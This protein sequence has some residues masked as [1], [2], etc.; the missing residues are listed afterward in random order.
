MIVSIIRAVVR[1]RAV[2]WLLVAALV[3]ASAYAIGTASLDAI[4]DISDPQIVVYAKWPRSA[5]LLETEVTAPLVS[6]LVGSPDIRG[7]R[8]ASH[9]GYA[10]IYVIL[11]D[12]ARR[13]R[14]QQLV[15][16]RL[17]AIRPQLPP[18]A[19]VTLGP[20]ASS[21]GWIYQYALV[22]GQGTHDLRELRLLN[23]SQIKPALQTVPGIA[24]VA[25]VGGLEKQYQIKVYPPLLAKAGIPLKQLI[26]AVQSVFQ[27][28]G[29]RMIEVTN[30]DYQ[31]RGIINSQDLDKLEL[32]VVG[33]TKEGAP[34]RLK[35]I[36]YVQVGYDQRRSTV[37]L[38]GT[39]EVVG[40]I[41]IMDQDGN[42]LAITR[43][44]EQKLQQLRAALPQGI[45]IVTTYDRSA[46]IWSTLRQFVETL[47]V[48]LGVLIVVTLLFLRNLRTAVGP[49]TILLLS[50]LFPVLPLVGF[51]QTVNLFSLAG[52]VIAIGEIADATIVIVEN[53]TAEL[54]AHGPA[55]RAE[56]Q[57]IV[58][59]SIASVAKPLLFSLLIILASFLPVF[60]LEEREARLF[61]PL[62]YSK[63]FAMAF[64]TL[65]TM[66]LLPLIVL[67]IF[68]HEGHAPRRFQETVAARAYR[69][70]LAAVIRYRYAFTGAGM[71]FLIPAAVLLTQFPRDFLPEVDEGAILYM[72]T[73]LPGLP[74]RE[75]GWILQQMDKKL[76]ALP[77]VERVFGK[78][79]RADTSTDPAPLT[80]IE[81]T[82][83]LQPRSKWRQDMTR[84]KLIAE[85]DKAVQT[86]GYVNAWVQPIRARVM[87]QST[88]I[89]TPV[90]LKVKGSDL[91]IIEDISQQVEGLLRA[92]PG[93]KSVIAER[94]S[95]GYYVDVRN[96]LE[97]M[98][99]RNVTVDEAMSTVRHAIGGDN[100]VSVRQADNT[101][102][103]LGVQYSPEYIDTLDKIKS[104]PVVTADGRSVPLGE[105]ADVSVRKMPEMIRNDNGSLAGYIYVDLQ[106][107]TGPDY[108]AGA[109]LML[110]QSL[111]L[112]TGYSIEWTGLYEYAAAARARLRV[113]VPLTLVIIFGLLVVA[114]KSV[115]ESVLIL[116]S[117]PFAM[118]GGVF[119]QWTLGY[120]MTTAVIVGY[121]SLFAVAVQTGIIMVI[122]IRA[123]LDSRK[124]GQSYVDAVLDGSAMRLRP[125][126]MTVAA[127]MLALL[128]VM[129][130][131]GTGME[132]LQPIAAP[133][134]GG[135]VSSTL[136]VLFMT[137]CLF[138]I[139]DDVRCWWER[140]SRA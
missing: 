118:V 73:T 31:L 95:E 6:A 113:I 112:P 37:D 97:R 12:T 35:D 4:P 38:D 3:V 25:S 138:V 63:T 77:E 2:V 79:G 53:C 111:T 82:V 116:L 52:L 85:M 70:A 93:T 91:S 122:F 100:I 107:V 135:M 139:G 130:T 13:D 127:T 105:V 7:I 44:L 33:R 30:R 119:L 45:E 56:R 18:D 83:L 80:M 120:P 64:S 121:I 96:D 98:A 46:W 29:G 78:I 17:N 41:A 55:T 75:A 51:R 36:G 59:R 8:G 74:N 109:Q 108:V 62:A 21:M 125:K 48:E 94:I 61:D 101:I 90:G 15:V 117:V 106:N 133:S 76:K 22:D 49:I 132:I 104:T 43:S 50:T 14:V 71:L 99:E 68:K 27:E 87:M 28:A 19:I 102:V 88:G 23:E 24:E 60:F 84:E 123:A 134:I 11:N 72:P 89:Q 57:E 69:T 40:G 129:F 136:H 16:D 131:S 47:A 26:A 34:I 66:F 115:A 124:E 86:V 32:L 81:T 128:P 114:F 10:F 1:W 126:L 137:P 67:W 58:V 65:L 9:M 39:G 110:A 20:N 103:P 5:Q 42:V 54:A 140:R 92:L